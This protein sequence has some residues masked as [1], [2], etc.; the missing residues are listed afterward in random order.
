[1]PIDLSV[2]VDSADTIIVL[3]WIEAL[4][5]A[6]KC[7]LFF[8]F[9]LVKIVGAAF[10]VVV[11]VVCLFF[12]CFFVFFFFLPGMTQLSRKYKSPIA[13]RLILMGSP[14]PTT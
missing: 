4:T 12:V 7:P 8:P 9:V 2:I 14:G 13:L 1:M 6:R 11:V 10:F 3:V 5:L